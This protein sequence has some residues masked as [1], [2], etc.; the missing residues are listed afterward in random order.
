MILSSTTKS[1]P[2]SPNKCKTNENDHSRSSSDISLAS[3]EV[4]EINGK[5]FVSACPHRFQHHQADMLKAGTN[6]PA[7]PVIPS[8]DYTVPDEAVGF[9]HHIN[10]PFW[11]DDEVN[12]RSNSAFTPT[13]D[14][15]LP[16]AVPFSK[17][18]NSTAP[19]PSTTVGPS[20]SISV[21]QKQQQIVEEEYEIVQGLQPTSGLADMAAP[22]VS[23][24]D[25]KKKEDFGTNSLAVKTPS[26]QTKTSATVYIEET[27]TS[28]EAKPPPIVDRSKKPMKKH[29]FESPPAVPE[30]QLIQHEK[31]IQKE[32]IRNKAHHE[33]P[34]IVLSRSPSPSTPRETSPILLSCAEDG[35]ISHDSE[36]FSGKQETSTSQHP[37]IVYQG[38]EIIS[39]TKT[40]PQ[41]H[42]E[43][44][45]DV[46][47]VNQS[48]K[49][50]NAHHRR[51]L[52]DYLN[53]GYISPTTSSRNS[54]RTNTPMRQ[55]QTED[56][57]GEEAIQL[58]PPPDYSPLSSPDSSPPCLAK[59]RQFLTPSPQPIERR[60]IE[61]LDDEDDV[62]FMFSS[63]E[64]G[65]NLTLPRSK[66][67]PGTPKSDTKQSPVT[68]QLKSP[69]S[70]SMSS[71]STP[72]ES[73]GST[74]KIVTASP[75]GDKQSSVTKQ[76][77]PRSTLTSSRNAEEENSGSTK[78]VE[79]SK[80]VDKESPSS[81]VIDRRSQPP[82]PPLDRSKKPTKKKR[83]VPIVP[84]TF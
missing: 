27:P 80:Q 11:S 17:K 26:L 43:A 67:A 58:V 59:R 65:D 31:Q 54:T 49:K 12:V 69:H 52:V 78:V 53:D 24:N 36:T 64:D 81:T 14:P 68:D 5:T 60:L 51:N 32:P 9:P 15:G 50:K 55:R 61:V 2:K 10:R 41:Q 82:P 46:Q 7:L 8:P 73:F 19:K 76:G 23:N 38:D 62:E 77:F 40:N 33:Q 70:T 34:M 22:L 30:K 21:K 57:G 29:E 72:E 71:N 20:G 18:I 1:P 45:G 56:S 79:L 44:N 25:P 35:V 42:L 28:L 48:Q 3:E 47:T 84:V 16:A 74:S 13:N 4:G 83:D 75:V 66:S 63:N 37:H 6:K 39:T